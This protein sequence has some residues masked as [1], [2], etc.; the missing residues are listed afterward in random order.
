MKAQKIKQRLAFIHAYAGLY[1]GL[2]P[3]PL[4]ARNPRMR[5]MLDG[6]GEF[7]KGATAADLLA[8]GSM[9]CSILERGTPVRPGM[10]ARQSREAIG[11]DFIGLGKDYDVWR[12]GITLGWIL[13]RFAPP[14][15]GLPA[16]LPVH[17]RIGIGVYAG[18][19]STEESTLL[20]DAFLLNE[21]TRA[22][23][24][25]MLGEGLK[26][27]KPST[28]AEMIPVHASLTRLNMNVA[29]YAR[30]TVLSA[31]A[32]VESFTNSVGS[33]AASTTSGLDPAVVE[34]LHGMR[35][36]RYLSLE[37]KLE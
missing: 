6:V 25:L 12:Y 24:D 29:T 36:G 18:S 32:F 26:V 15:L 3:G 2:D 31:V 1:W 34:Q 21:L 35:K 19:V 5:E 9:L 17:A 11:H 23:N 37:Y 22:A 10:T 4:G 13:E 30:S 27:A 33:N 20:E 8:R 16:D 7:I 28:V 14:L